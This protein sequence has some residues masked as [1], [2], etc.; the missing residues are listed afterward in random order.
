[1]LL[2]DPCVNVGRIMSYVVGVARRGFVYKLNNILHNTHS[3]NTHS[4]SIH[5]NNNTS[6]NT[7][8]GVNSSANNNL[9]I[10]GKTP[11]ISSKSKRKLYTKF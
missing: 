5:S 8:N 10:I 11:P 3:N 2:G 9:N 7:P 6:T 1:M 4:N